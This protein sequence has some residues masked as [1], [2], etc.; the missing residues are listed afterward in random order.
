MDKQLPTIQD[1]PVVNEYLSMLFNQNK[2]KD[3]KDTKEMIDYIAGMEVQLSDVL[4]ELQG[5]KEV[6][7]QIQNPTTKM[8]LNEVFAKTETFINDGK[9]KLSNIK[10][11]ILYS[12]KECLHDFKQKGKMGVIKVV[13]ISHFKESIEGLKKSLFYSL[14]QIQKVS[15]TIDSMTFQFRKSKTGIKNIGRLLMGKP[16]QS[17]SN[18]I[19]NLNIMQKSCRNMFFG[20][21]KLAIRTTKFLHRIDDFEKSSVKKDIKLIT[22]PPKY[23]QKQNIVK[24]QSR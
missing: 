11:E 16:I 3:F 21:E 4:K 17:N 18:D 9:N 24:G 12:M 23:K 2:E 8:R 20:L 14:K 15:S 7:N 13:H 1:N 5:I 22:Y 6:L 19:N 10:N